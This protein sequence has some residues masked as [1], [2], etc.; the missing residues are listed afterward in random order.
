VVSD[1]WLT[2]DMGIARIDIQIKVGEFVE[3]EPVLPS[4]A[5]NVT[6][7]PDEH[8]PKVTAQIVSPYDKDITNVRI[9]AIL[10]NDAG[11]IIGGGCSYLDY[12]PANG[13]AAAEV[14]VA[15]TGIRSTIE[16]YATVSALSELEE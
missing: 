1:L 16:L 11:E 5:E 3:S 2:S 9:S 6:Y 14:S 15:S 13:K 12:V 4:T 10:Y 7:V 8:F